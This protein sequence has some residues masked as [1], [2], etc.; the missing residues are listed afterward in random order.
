MPD[1][2]EK[3]EYY[4]SGPW[5]LNY[6]SLQELDRLID[7]EWRRLISYREEKI[8]EAVEAEISEYSILHEWEKK[9]RRT[10]KKDLRERIESRYKYESSKSLTILYSN[11]R[12][13]EVESFVAANRESK[14]ST[15]TPTGFILIMR[16]AD[17]SCSIQ[18]PYT[19]TSIKLHVAPD[20]LSESRE[21]FTVIR[22]WIESKRPPLWQRIWTNLSGLH[23]LLLL[24]YFATSLQFFSSTGE[25]GRSQYR[26]E[27]V[28]L[29]KDG[30]SDSEKTRAVELILCFEARLVP[31]EYATPIPAWFWWSSVFA[32]VVA[33]LLSFA[34]KVILGLGDG[35]AA[36]K[37]WRTYSTFVFTS[38]PSWFFG[39]FFLPKLADLIRAIWK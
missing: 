26:K 24:I 33:I 39:T 31:D 35:Q 38:I 9:D 32:I 27:A 36:I 2:I 6:E 8:R 20:T 5:L 11:D 3:T 28:Q 29:L 7:E 18:L 23:W 4:S 21:L 25:A 12:R 19:S 22:S 16:C 13:L 15:D 14:C 17:V 10:L 37:K 30:L 1:L 34:P